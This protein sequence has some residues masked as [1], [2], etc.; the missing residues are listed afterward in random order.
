MKLLAAF[1]MS[2]AYAMVAV[3]QTTSPGPAPAATMGS[4]SIGN[5]LLDDLPTAVTPAK[6]RANEN[7]D[8]AANGRASNPT[9]QIDNQGEDIGGPNNGPLLLARVRN[10][11]QRAGMLLGH[12][13]TAP[14]TTTVQ[15][16]A[17]AQKRVVAQLDSLI[18][19]L[20]K[21]CQGGQCQP[22]TNPSPQPSQRSTAKPSQS[23]RTAR[24]GKAPAR[25]SSD[26]LNR[27]EAQP[28]DRHDVGELVKHLW[29]HL[30]ERSREQVLQSFSVEFLPKY[31]L[32]IEE[33]YRQLSDEESDRPTR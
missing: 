18:A 19:E 17:E 1:T 10:D 27:T 23:N 25:D 2:L 9:P 14:N 7:G 12:P 15:Q 30:P 4:E 3:A 6:P 5:Q 22:N 16:A 33:Y 31:E 26:P 8:A 32:E 13:L 11:M 28:V 20:S 29:G 21:Q 24:T